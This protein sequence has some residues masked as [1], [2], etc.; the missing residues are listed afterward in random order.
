LRFLPVSALKFATHQQ[1]KFLVSAAEFHVGFQRDGVVALHQRIEQFVHGDGFFRL[2]A[3]VEV[4][5][6]EY[7]RAGVLGR[8]PHEIVRGKLP[9]PATIE[10]H[11]G[12]LRI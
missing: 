10:I 7:L 11:D 3:L 5:A 1:I 2:K 8:E 6:L 12:F 9:E 4:F